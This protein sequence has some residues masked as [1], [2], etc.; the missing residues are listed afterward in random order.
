MSASGLHTYVYLHAPTH[1]IHSTPHTS[2]P[3]MSVEVLRRFELGIMAALGKLRQEP[4]KFKASQGCVSQKEKK[5]NQSVMNCFLFFS[6]E[7]FWSGILTEAKE[8]S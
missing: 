5:I 2:A 6:H 1:K 7:L 4:Q 8:P 3:K